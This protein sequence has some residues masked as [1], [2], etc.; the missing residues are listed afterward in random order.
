MEAQ[1]YLV[2]RVETW[3]MKDGLLRRP[4]SNQRVTREEFRSQ[5]EPGVHYVVYAHQSG[6]YSDG[7]GGLPVWKRMT[8]H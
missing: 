7:S 8:R 5:K 2:G 1:R 4:L 3:L 6:T